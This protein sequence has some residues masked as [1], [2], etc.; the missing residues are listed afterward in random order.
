MNNHNDQS[1][2]H[3]KTRIEFLL[4]TQNPKFWDYALKSDDDPKPNKTNILV[5]AVK[6]DDDT[7]TKQNQYPGTML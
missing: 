1:K 7:K 4:K 6:S 3:N 2:I 5:Y